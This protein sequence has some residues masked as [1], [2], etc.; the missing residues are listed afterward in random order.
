M[1]VIKNIDWER[2]K[3]WADENKNKAMLG[4][5]AI[6]VVLAVLAERCSGS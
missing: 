6:V 1:A 3:A 4:I 2:V 5:F